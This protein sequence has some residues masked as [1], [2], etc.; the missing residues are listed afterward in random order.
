VSLSG[1]EPARLTEINQVVNSLELPKF[2][3]ITWKSADGLEIEGFL[4]TP[5]AAASGQRLP[6][7]LSIHGGPAGVFRT[8]FNERNSVLAA[9]GWAILEPNVRGSTSYGDAFL[10]GN[11]RDIG[12]GDYRDAMAGVDL[13]VQ[14]GIADPERLA[15]RGWSYGGILGGWTVTQTTR[16]K[17]A[18]LGAMVTD[19]ASEY[20]MGFNHDV[21]LWYIGGTPWENPDGYKRQSSYTHIARVTTPTLLLHGEQDDTCTIGQSM[22][23]YQGLKDRNVA[24]RFVRFPR[25]PHGFREPHHIRMRDVEEIKWLMK[26]TRGIDW[27][28]PDRK[29]SPDPA[30]TTTTASQ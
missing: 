4:W 6:L 11:V 27:S 17:A 2:K 25:E 30:K 15:V 20:A 28:L 12:G 18:S 5:A 24:A 29:D 9:L 1:G 14:Q 3:A 10:S 7:L 23:F 16:F 21:R 8:E 26:H 13:L 19:W 22:M